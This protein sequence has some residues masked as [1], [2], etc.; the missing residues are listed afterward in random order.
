MTSVPDPVGPI[1]Q[2]PFLRRGAGEPGLF[3]FSPTLVLLHGYGKTR[4]HLFDR[5][6]DADQRLTILGLQAPMR[7]GPGAYRWFDYTRHPDSTITIDAAEEASSHATLVAFLAALRASSKTPLFLLGH[8][9]GGMMALGV[10]LARPDLV[11]GCAVVNARVLPQ[12]LARIGDGGA[13]STSF[14]VGHGLDDETVPVV[15]GRAV[16]DTLARLGAAPCYRE[17]A[18]GHDVTAGMLADVSAWLTRQLSRNSPSVRPLPPAATVV[19]QVA[20]N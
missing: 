1:T 5:V 7:I 17:Y 4:N 16:R 19:G 12:A 10:A 11:E 14:F 13:C 15:R 6:Q 3:D 9:Q 18:A 8:S 2:V 20:G